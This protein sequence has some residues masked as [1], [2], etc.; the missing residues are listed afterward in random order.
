MRLGDQYYVAE[1][2]TGI[3]AV[4][5]E[6][7]YVTRKIRCVSLPLTGA[8]S[9]L[10]AS[11]IALFDRQTGERREMPAGTEMYYQENYVEG[12]DVM[13]VSFGIQLSGGSYEEAAA[14]LDSSFPGY[15]LDGQSIN[16][17]K[18]L[19]HL[20]GGKDVFLLCYEN[21]KDFCHRHRAAKWLS[22]C[23]AS[24]TEWE[25]EGMM[26]VEWEQMSFLH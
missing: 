26:D 6:N 23:G 5:D 25:G 13:E 8:V 16:V 11:S 18:D 19:E 2:G 15:V 17:R 21:P 3:G 10:D 20:S 4:P 24:V 12:M 14:F 1:S 9:G 7:K 22:S